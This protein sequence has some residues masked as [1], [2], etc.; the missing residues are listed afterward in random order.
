VSWCF[1][2]DYLPDED[3]TIDMPDRYDFLRGYRASFWTGPQLAWTDIYP[4]TLKPRHRAI[5][6]EEPFVGGRDG[7]DLWH[8]GRILARVNFS[9]GLLSSDITLVNWPQID[10]WLGSDATPGRLP[11]LVGGRPRLR[12]GLAKDATVRE[13]L[14][15]GTPS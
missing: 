8:Y 7:S 4:D 3:H 2:L 13:P 15:K 5:F 12:A 6:D 11:A 10:Y 9:G 14:R 1:P